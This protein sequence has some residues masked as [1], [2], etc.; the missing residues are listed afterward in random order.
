MSFAELLSQ[1][2]FLSITLGQLVMWVIGLVLIYL[3]I[4]KKY[5]PY[6]LLPIGF[7]TIL[8]NVPLGGMIGDE[9][10]IRIMYYGIQYEV[11][12]PM[13]FLGLGAMTD[14]GPLIANP[15][16]MLLG[17]GAQVGVFI[18]FFGALALG[19]TL[20]EAASIGIIGGADGP[21]T[22]FLTNAKAAHILGATAVSAYSYMALVPV[23]IPPLARL[24]TSK[25]ERS[26]VMK[27][28]RPV[29]KR[30]RI[31]FP[32]VAFLMVA[33]LVPK[34]APL[35]GMFMMGNLMRE[36]GVVKRL[37]DGAQ[38]EM[39]NI[40]TIVLGLSISLKLTAAAFLQW[41]V[42]KVFAL[43]LVAFSCSVVG[44][45]MLAKLMNL[46]LK[47]KINPLVGAAGLSA[48][49][50]AARVIQIEGMK[51]NPRNYLL[52]HAMGPNV[53]GVI[54]TLVAAGLFMTLV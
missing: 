5:E 28:G 24:M 12:P 33:L 48:V 27:Q 15:K 35:M 17:A 39:M 4:A 11:I 20:P 45:I 46:F 54:G 10:L 14:F 40:M 19:F 25:E 8:V 51:A 34:S 37:A 18:A 42:L 9:G 43:G 16:M 50:M 6:L 21:T 3:A 52:M 30:E 29:K 26:V 32:L 49:P 7:G 31:L 2:G 53:A 22:I 36:S 23:I 13:I 47:E 41:Q 38:N 1:T 44:G